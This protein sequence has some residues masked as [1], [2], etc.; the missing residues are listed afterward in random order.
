MKDQLLKFLL[1]ICALV[2]FTGYC[3]ALIE[4]VQDY[5]TGVYSRHHF[6]ALYETSGIIM[7]TLLGI[8]FT[9]NRINIF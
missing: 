4:W 5:K 3:Y 8:R 6:E 2:C 9:K 7:Y 1:G